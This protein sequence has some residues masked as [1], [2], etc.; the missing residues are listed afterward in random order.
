MGYEDNESSYLQ[1]AKHERSLDYEDGTSQLDMNTSKEDGESGSYKCAH[2][3]KVFL[4]RETLLMHI[5]CH[6]D[7]EALRSSGRSDSSHETAFECDVCSER[8]LLQFQLNMH[9][10]R[11]AENKPYECKVC[12]KKF[13]KKLLLVAHA[14]L[15]PYTC[16]VCHKTFSRMTEVDVH[17]KTHLRQ[18]RRVFA[19]SVCHK[20]YSRKTSLRDH[21]R[22]H[23]GDLPFACSDC[24]KRFSRAGVLAKHR[25]SH[26]K[27][28][29]SD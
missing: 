10:K 8:F 26:V 19:C 15:K 25:I 14:R 18:K 12:G 7:E 5:K 1:D 13:E 23:T 16:H 2:C 24:P 3:V 4:R 11:H 20:K 21:I 17:R 9:K 22:V 27:R 28:E 6:I 29:K